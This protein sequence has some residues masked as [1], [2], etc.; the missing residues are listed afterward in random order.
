MHEGRLFRRRMKKQVL[1]PLMFLGEIATLVITAKL[2]GLETENSILGADIDENAI[3][4][5]LRRVEGK[6]RIRRLTISYSSRLRNV[7]VMVLSSLLCY[8]NYWKCF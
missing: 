2:F 8:T 7:E 5:H 6:D 1:F 3:Y 4:A